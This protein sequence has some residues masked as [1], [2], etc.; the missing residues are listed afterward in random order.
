MAEK[1]RQTIKAL[2]FP[3]L[4]FSGLLPAVVGIAV[5][6][7]SM[8]YGATPYRYV[9]PLYRYDEITSG[10]DEVGLATVLIVG[11]AV[12]GLL[13][14]SLISLK[15]LRHPKLADH[16]RHCSY[17]CVFL[18]VLNAVLIPDYLEGLRAG[19]PEVETQGQVVRLLAALGI[20]VNA[21]ILAWQRRSFERA[22]VGSAA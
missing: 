3:F 7:G 21:S 17:L 13:G 2:V 1:M 16:L 18:G 20:L 6:F 12:F 22:D 5:A 19:Y 15:G 8:E 11:V 4:H 10:F 9:E 14:W